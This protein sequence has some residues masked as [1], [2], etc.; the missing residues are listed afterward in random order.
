MAT[1]SE[2]ADSREL[3]RGFLVDGG[4]AVDL[5]GL[6][7]GD[8]GEVA[9]LPGILAGFAAD[10]SE[11][12]IPHK[13]IERFG[14]ADD[15]DECMANVDKKFEGQGEAIAEQAGR[16]ED[17]FSAIV[18]DIAVA[19][20]LIAELGCV[21]RRHQ[22]CFAAATV[23]ESERHKVVSFARQRARDGDRDRLDHALEVTAA[24]VVVAE[25]CVT[26]TVRCL[27]H[28]H[29]MDDLRCLD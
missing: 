28:G 14:N 10:I 4:L 6:T 25:C 24:E 27:T 15:V 5:V 18:G 8:K 11:S 3:L 13:L 16:D 19:D 20:G 2:K 17:A 1:A 12:L 26:D 9:A 29:F 21:G 7:A 23:A 22:R